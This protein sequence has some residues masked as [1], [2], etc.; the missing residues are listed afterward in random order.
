MFNFA[1]AGVGNLGKI[2]P[3]ENGR[4]VYFHDPSE[5][6]GGN[7][8]D[9]EAEIK[10][11]CKGQ[12]GN[13][14]NG[15]GSLEGQLHF[16]FNKLCD[17]E[18][19]NIDLHIR[20]LEPQHKDQEKAELTPDSQSEKITKD[21]YDYPLLAES[22]G[23][24]PRF[25]IK[26]R[27]PLDNPKR[28]FSISGTLDLELFLEDLTKQ[29]VFE[30]ILLFDAKGNVV[31]QKASE[32]FTWSNLNEIKN[33][34]SDDSFFGYFGTSQPLEKGIK[35]DDATSAPQ[36]M[37]I[38][39]PTGYQKLFTQPVYLP[40]PSSQNKPWIIAGLISTESFRQEYLAISS[41]ALLLIMVALLAFVL[42]M[43]MMRLKMMGATDPLRLTTFLS[44]HSHLY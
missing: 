25:H 22:K 15:S 30:E 14:S 24:S 16:V 12:T 35:S 17:T 41:R 44:L 42:A 7:E 19:K 36:V 40:S 6:F 38:E 2:S 31:Y 23:R 29:S 34:K 39:T 1:L 18:L 9:Q 32:E 3:I 4:K 33:R 21:D 5:K 37:T 26:Y 20:K 27:V 13:V 11:F 8:Q 28:K 10:D 43:P